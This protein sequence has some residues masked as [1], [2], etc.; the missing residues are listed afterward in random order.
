VLVVLQGSAH[1]AIHGGATVH[2]GTHIDD[3]AWH[4]GLRAIAAT[5]AVRA[6]QAAGSETWRQLRAAEQHTVSPAATEA[7]AAGSPAPPAA[8]QLHNACVA[9]AAQ[10]EPEP[11]VPQRTTAVNAQELESALRLHGQV[12]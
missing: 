3:A 9:T 5:A 1:R 2:L 12:G 10:P 4:K 11:A 7:A 8:G 6:A